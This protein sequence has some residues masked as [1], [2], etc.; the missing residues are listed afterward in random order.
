MKK[1][2]LHK[3]IPI[4]QGKTTKS[5]SAARK[6]KAELGDSI[7]GSARKTN[8]S[9]NTVQ[10][11]LYYDTGELKYEGFIKDGTPCGMGIKYY[12]NGQKHLEGNF[13]DWFIESGR[14]YYENGSL[15]FEGKYNSGPRSYYGPRYFVSGRLYYDTGE[16]WYEGSFSFTHSSTGYPLFK[17]SESFCKGVEY[18]KYGDIIEIHSLK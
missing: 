11:K 15:R 13:A 8:S 7:A 10:G 18:N 17:G 5:S 12:K 3:V 2:L 4:P 6:R 9:S 1:H 14:E 16:L